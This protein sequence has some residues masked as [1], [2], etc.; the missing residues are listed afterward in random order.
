MHLMQSFNDFK[1]ITQK[2]FIELYSS[3]IELFL[4]CYLVVIRHPLFIFYLPDEVRADLFFNIKFSI[5][6]AVQFISNLPK[7]RKEQKSDPKLTLK[8]FK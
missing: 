4:K 1:V 3:S 5:K 2:D 6:R 8:F 7:G